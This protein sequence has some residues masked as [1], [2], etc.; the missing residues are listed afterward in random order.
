MDREDVDLEF[1]EREKALIR[2]LSRGDA[3]DHPVR[4][5]RVL[6]T[7]ISWVVLTGDFAYKI[8]KPI[9]LDFLDYSTLEKRRH[10]CELELELNRRWAPD[11]YLDVVPICGS[12]REP[13]V[14]G[15]GEPIE[16]ALKM[17]EFPQSAQL[18]AQLV[19]GLLSETD[20]VPLA[21]TGATRAVIS[22]GE[23]NR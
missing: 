2:S 21:E 19:A 20:M 17:K 10:F 4:E 6:D 13:V 7:H 9:R 8:K 12:F 3:Y 11:I 14:G 1:V 22:S 18:D 23:T 16:Y 5:L 15:E